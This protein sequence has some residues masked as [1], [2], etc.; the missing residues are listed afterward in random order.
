MYN[1]LAFIGKIIKEVEFSQQQGGAISK[2]AIS[3]VRRYVVNGAEKE[4]TCPMDIVFFGNL[5]E[6]ANRQL[7]KGSSVLV[8]GRPKFEQWVDV[9][10]GQKRSKHILIV[11]VLEILG[12]PVDKLATP[13]KEESAA[14]EAKIFTQK[15]EEDP[16]FESSKSNQ[17]P[18]KD[19]EEFSSVPISNLRGY[20]QPTVHA[21]REVASMKEVAETYETFPV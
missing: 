21:I 11:L 18:L 6:T 13:I 19:K 12:T 7:K 9:L 5:A 14:P 16:N 4:D 20:V 2:S 15:R 1:K 10:S 17:L 8:E 3:V